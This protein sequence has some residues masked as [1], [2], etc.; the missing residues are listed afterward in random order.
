MKQGPS[1]S[2]RGDTKVEPKSHAVSVDAVA[3]IGVH[4][5]DTRP[6]PLFEGRGYK[7]PGI[8]SSTHPKGSQGRH[9]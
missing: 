1:S 6:E 4:H 9:E 2:R 7:A 5:I 3:D 8:A